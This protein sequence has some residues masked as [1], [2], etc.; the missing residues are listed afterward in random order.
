MPAVGRA[1]DVA[2]VV[3]AGAAVDDAAVVQGHEHVGG[4]RRA[5]LADL[6]VGA[7]GDVGVAAA[8][9]LG[10]V[11]DAAELVGRRRCRRGSAGGT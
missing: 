4:V 8:E 11:G 2:D 7:G 10:E 1:G 3:G 9:L 6:E 5:D